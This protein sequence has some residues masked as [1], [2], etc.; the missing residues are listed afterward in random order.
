MLGSGLVLIP[1]MVTGWHISRA[2]GVFLLLLYAVYIGSMA[3]GYGR[4]AV[5]A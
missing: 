3:L 1:I 4:P 2:E 5:P